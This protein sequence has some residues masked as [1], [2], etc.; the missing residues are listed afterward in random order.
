MDAGRARRAR[1]RPHYLL[2]SSR[3]SRVPFSPTAVPE[4]DLHGQDGNSFLYAET[5]GC[6]I[7]RYYFAGPLSG[8]VEIIVPDLPGYPDNI[9]RSSDGHYWCALVGMRSPAFDLA[10]RMPEFR[11]RM[12]YR[13]A[14]DE[15][16]FP[17]MNTGCV[18]KFDL[19]GNIIDV[20]WDLDGNIHPMITSMREHKGTLYLSGVFNNRIGTYKFPNAD[21]NWCA[22][23]TYWGADVIGSLRPGDRQFPRTR[24]GGRHRAGHGRAAGAQPA[25]G[26]RTAAC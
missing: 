11:R 7:S 12:V 25:S 20:L 21:P 22:L 15:W 3:G 1:Q 10:L 8:K 17:N 18:I 2:R 14:P 6:R 23:D 16:L 5:W 9:N 13:V 19:Q 24:R 4:W 26:S